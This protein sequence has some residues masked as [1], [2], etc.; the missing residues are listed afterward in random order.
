M[1]KLETQ[2]RNFAKKRAFVAQDVMSVLP[3]VIL[4]TSN[5]PESRLILEWALI[6]ILSWFHCTQARSRMRYFAPISSP[7]LKGLTVEFGFEFNC[8]QP[9]KSCLVNQINRLSQLEVIY[10]YIVD[11]SNIWG[12]IGDNY[13]LYN[14]TESVMF[15]HCNSVSCKLCFCLTFFFAAI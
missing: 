10:S 8:G 15:L 13:S 12:R 11:R 6:P 14:A 1:L 9:N 2:L 3:T 5:A 4:L 7:R